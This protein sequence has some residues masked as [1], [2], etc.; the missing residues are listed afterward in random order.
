MTLVGFYFI[1]LFTLCVSLH[2]CVPPCWSQGWA[3]FTGLAT[4]VFT[5]WAIL[6]TQIFKITY[7][8]VYF[9]K[10]LLIKLQHFKSIRIVLL[11]NYWKVRTQLL[12]TSIKSSKK[13]FNSQKHQVNF[14]KWKYSVKQQSLN[15]LTNMIQ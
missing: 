1:C 11:K 5:W 9:L 12:F 14:E 6:P 7:N 2:L 13:L 3:L 10:H 4:S 15:Q 8:L